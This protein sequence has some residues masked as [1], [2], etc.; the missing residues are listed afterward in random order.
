MEIVQGLGKSVGDAVE[1]PGLKE[2]ASSKYF[3]NRTKWLQS[4]DSFC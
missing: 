4:V 2:R 3:V 1:G